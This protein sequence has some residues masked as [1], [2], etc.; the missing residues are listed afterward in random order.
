MVVGALV[1]LAILIGW[2]RS[3]WKKNEEGEEQLLNP[4]PS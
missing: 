2:A 1:L 4:E 3:V